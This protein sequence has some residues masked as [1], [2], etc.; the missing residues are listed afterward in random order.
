MQKG[1]SKP[2][3][4]GISKERFFEIRSRFARYL[5]KISFNQAIRVYSFIYIFNLRTTNRVNSN[6]LEGGRQV[7][8]LAAEQS[9][10]HPNVL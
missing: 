8:L 1:S 7:M 5:T 4:Y 9:T 2:W 6:C 10:I 3:L